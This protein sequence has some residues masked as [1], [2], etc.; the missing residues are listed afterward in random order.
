LDTLLPIFVI[1]MLSKQMNKLA[2]LLGLSGLNGSVALAALSGLFRPGNA[3]SL[4]ILFMAGPVAIMTAI[5]FEGVARERMF[6]ALLAGI[7]ATIIV[8]L[9]AGLGPKLLSFVNLN[10]LKIVGGLAILS[11]GLLVMGLKIPERLPTI[12]MVIGL[13]ISLLWR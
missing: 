4:A 11:I 6:A 2:L 9:A 12:I 13:I 1:E 10:I 5:L 8:V 7:I 3:F